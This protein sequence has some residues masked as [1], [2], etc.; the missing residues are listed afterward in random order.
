M[1]GVSWVSGH[2][3][4]LG[5]NLSP[6]LPTATNWMT[7]C[8]HKLCVFTSCHSTDIL[9][10]LY[11]KTGEDCS[12]PPSLEAPRNRTQGFLKFSLVF[13]K[14]MWGHSTTLDCT[15]A[16]AGPWSHAQWA[17][18]IILIIIKTSEHSERFLFCS[19]LSTVVNSEC[20]CLVLQPTV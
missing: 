8:A 6:D 9:L 15:W 18:L 4:H 13:A 1:L 10:K 19:I 2:P 20:L 17:L 3:V 12:M 14:K 11:S 7:I 5:K 16:R